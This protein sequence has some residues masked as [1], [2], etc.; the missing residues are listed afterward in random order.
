MPAITSVLRR[1]RSAFDYRNIADKDL[2]PL[3][4]IHAHWLNNKKA[5]RYADAAPERSEFLVEK[6]GE[7]LPTS[8]KI[9]EVG[10][11]AGRNLHFLHQAGYRNL[12]AVELSPRAVDYLRER[13]PDLSDVPIQVMPVEDVAK[14][15]RENQF[16]LTFSMAV[17]LHIHPRSEWVFRKMAK[18]SKMVFTIEA[19]TS[20]RWH[21]FPRNYEEVFTSFG[22]KQIAQYDNVYGLPLYTG[23]LF[24]TSSV[25]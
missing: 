13:F 4:A 7:Y 19:E 21:I 16:D 12:E 1:I 24:D 2:T 11:N 8:A 25:R 6:I 18:A 14:T 23:R 10:C 3:K 9:F 22:A 20:E 17:L 5:E 15:W